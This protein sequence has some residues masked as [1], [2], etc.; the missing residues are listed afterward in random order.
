MAV[1]SVLIHVLTRVVACGSH[2]LYNSLHEV[3]QLVLGASDQIVQSMLTARVRS[4]KILAE[5][6][7]LVY[8]VRDGVQNAQ[9]LSLSC[10]SKEHHVEFCYICSS[11]TQDGETR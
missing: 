1:P 4:G 8:N 3:W 6:V 5:S 2:D 11:L 10:C 9:T 7:L